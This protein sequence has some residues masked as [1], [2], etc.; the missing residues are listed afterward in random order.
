MTKLLVEYLKEMY[1]V[2]DNAIQNSDHTDFEHCYWALDE[3]CLHV[4]LYTEKYSMTYIPVNM[5]MYDKDMN[6]VQGL[7]SKEE[8]KAYLD[9]EMKLAYK[10]FGKDKEEEDKA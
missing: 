6:Y 9:D 5:K 10:L 7:M 2:L 8:E 1:A 3:L 4:M